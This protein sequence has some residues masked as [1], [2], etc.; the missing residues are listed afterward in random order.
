MSGASSSLWA[1]FFPDRNQLFSAPSG[2]RNDASKILIVITDGRKQGDSLDYKDVIPTAEVVGIIRYA[3]G[4]RCGDTLPL[5][6]LLASTSELFF[7][8]Q[9]PQLSQLLLPLE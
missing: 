7:Q 2:A 5:L 3:V 1:L 6:S 8:G 9:K 4:V